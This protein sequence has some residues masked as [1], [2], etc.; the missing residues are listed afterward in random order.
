MPF[1]NKAHRRAMWAKA[2]AVARRWTQKYGSKPKPK[3]KGKS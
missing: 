1:R 2:P 3:R